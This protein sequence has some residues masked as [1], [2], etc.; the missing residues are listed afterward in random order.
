MTMPL[1]RRTVLRALACSAATPA[2]AG[3]ARAGQPMR[4]LPPNVDTGPLGPLPGEPYP[5][6]N[7][8][9]QPERPEPRYHP[10]SVD[11]P[12][13]MYGP[14]QDEP[15]P[16]PRVKLSIIRPEFM[17]QFVAYDLGAE[18]GSLVIDPAAHHLYFVQGDGT[19]VRYGVGVGR[20]GFGWAGEAT[21]RFK[22]PWPDWYPPPEMLERQ[23]ELAEKMQQ[24]QSGIGMPGGPGNPLGARAMYLWQGNKDTL[25]RVHGT[26]EPWTIGKSVSSGCIRMINQDAIDLYD[27][28]AVGARVVVL[29]AGVGRRGKGGGFAG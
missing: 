5:W 8:I 1:S 25:Y 12:A 14:V 11:D 10:P 29:G 3:I 24:L 18:A 16:V 4:V 23:P 7:D 17:R 22:R 6:G 15:F 2:L 27:R 9:I 28:V 20:S 19:A 13:A 21:I 26:V